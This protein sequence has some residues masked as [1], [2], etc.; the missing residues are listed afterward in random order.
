MKRSSFV[1]L[2]VLVIVLPKAQSLKPKTNATRNTQRLTRNAGPIQTESGPVSGYF[3]EKTSVTAFKGIPFAA[4]PV[5][6]LRWKAPQPPIPWKAVKECTAFGPSPMQAK[7]VSFLMI[8]PEFVVPQQPLSEDCLYLNIWTAA[9]SMKEKRPVLVWIYGGGFQT[10]GSAAPGYSGEALAEQGILFVSFNYRLGIFGF[11]SHPALTAESIHHSSGNYA[12]MDMIAALSW[13]KKNIGAFGGDPDRVTIAGQSAGSASVNC[14]LASPVARGLFQGAIGES[15][16]LVLENPILHM[17]TLAN[18][19]KE[20]E[21]I[22]GKLDVTDLASL[23]ALPADEIQKKA[24]GFFA[25]IIDGYIMPASVAEIYKNDRQTHVPLL[26]GW[27]GDEGFIFGISSKEDFAKQSRSFGADSILF[28]K[29]FPSSSDS[30]SIS[31]QIS[32]AVDKTIALS[33]YQ[34]ASKQNVNGNPKTFLYV[35][36]RKPPAEGEK[37]RFGAYHTAEIGYALHNLDSIGRRWE[38]PDRNLEKLMSGYW[39]QFVKT[40]DPNLP[41]LQHWGPFTKNNPQ[42]MIFADT[43]AAML[44]PNKGALDFLYASYPGK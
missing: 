9:R 14:L 27:N 17:A 12:L 24:G 32:L 39:V 5:G 15:G 6:G 31:S 37:K 20:G 13:V 10:G 35:F 43:C 1:L 22:A 44:L 21:R 11:L 29:Y 34:W 23:R 8:G 28:T 4:P 25:P 30:E 36:T 33:Q 7:P 38:P 16:S 2:L 3:N 19:E 42:S 40:G 18:A 26:A 41:G